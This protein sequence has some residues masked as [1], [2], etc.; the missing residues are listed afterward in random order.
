VQ[1][2]PFFGLNSYHV[3]LALVGVIVIAARCPV[4]RP[5]EKILPLSRVG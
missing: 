3:T 2:E 4:R 1:N 5:I